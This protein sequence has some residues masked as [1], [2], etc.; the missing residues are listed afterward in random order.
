MSTV[1]ASKEIEDFLDTDPH[2]LL[3][4]PEN[5]W[6]VPDISLELWDTNWRRSSKKS[7]DFL[8]SFLQLPYL[9]LLMTLKTMETESDG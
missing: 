8:V 5:D 9:I 1:S 4:I 7:L 2:I 6:I 3:Y